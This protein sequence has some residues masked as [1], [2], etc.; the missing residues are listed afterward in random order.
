MK[1]EIIQSDDFGQ[2]L[3][4]GFKYPYTES[5]IANTPQQVLDHKHEL[6]RLGCKR[7][8]LVQ[9]KKVEQVPA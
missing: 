3:V 8:R 2:V 4:T 1:A 6:E 9:V 5:R 7:V